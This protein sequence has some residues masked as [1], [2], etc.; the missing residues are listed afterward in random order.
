LVSLWNIKPNSPIDIDSINKKKGNKNKDPGVANEKLHKSLDAI[1]EED[2]NA[3]GGDS[4]EKI[5]SVE[6]DERS[7]LSALS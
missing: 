3:G 1:K 7:F 2:K 4:F 5:N 6:E